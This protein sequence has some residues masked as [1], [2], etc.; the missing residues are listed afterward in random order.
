[1]STR[2]HEPVNVILN[3]DAHD[4]FEAGLS[5]REYFA[6]IAMQGLVSGGYSQRPE[7]AKL[8]VDYADALIIELNKEKPNAN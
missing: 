4:V 8:A 6:A 5:K 7:S 2:G 3:K 1:M